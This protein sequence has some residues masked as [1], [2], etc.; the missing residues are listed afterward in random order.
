MP[1]EALESP[2]MT[3]ES[4]KSTFFRQ[5]GWMM[6]ATVVSGIFMAFINIYSSRML[7]AN[8]YAGFATLLQM[9]NWMGIP[10]IGLQMVFAQQ[11]SAVITDAQRRQLV[12]TTK[13]VLTWTFCLWLLMALVGVIFHNQIVLTLH[14]SNPISFWLTV[15]VGFVMLWYPIFQGLLQGRQN[16]L[17]LGWTSLF[18]GV[19]RVF[20]GIVIVYVFHGWAAGLM[21]G[22]LIGLVAALGTGLWQS[23]DLL[24]EPSDPCHALGWLKRV[25]PLT[26][27]LGAGMFLFTADAFVVQ[28]Y[29]GGD[30]GHLAAPYMFGGTLA[31][32][33]VLFTGPLAVVMFPKLVHSAARSQKSDLMGVT[34][35]GTAILGC[36]AVL[37][38]TVTA[39]LLVKYG[40]TQANAAILPLLPLFAWTMVPFGTANVL[41]YNLMAH[42]RFKIVPAMVILSV[43]YW[44]A[45][46][47]FH[48]SFKMVIETFGTFSL[49][50]LG[51]C[52]VFTWLVDR[53]K[54]TV[55][56]N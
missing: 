44:L 3:A 34:L 38:L 53:N 36:V 28:S 31:R 25:V 43:G 54:T 50:Y 32:A 46:Q 15:L 5:S 29:L 39:P 23:R 35:A 24:G 7:P 2:K 56:S 19:G 4:H 45:L 8:E 33:I 6:I 17:W 13:A 11:T 9:V 40:S 20:I 30:D 49:I 26:L 55:K 41:L 42:S 47:H 22:V 37:G 52:A 21:A 16:F 27:G 51:I 18:N 48:D 1:A 10:A 12:G 14:L